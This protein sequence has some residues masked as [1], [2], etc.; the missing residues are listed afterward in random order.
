MRDFFTR[1]SRQR[2]QERGYETETRSSSELSHFAAREW[3]HAWKSPCQVV[4]PPPHH[5]WYGILHGTF[6]QF[7][8]FHQISTAVPLIWYP[9]SGPF[10]FL[11]PL[12]L[13]WLLFPPPI[14]SHLVACR[15]FLCMHF[16]PIPIYTRD[17]HTR[18]E[19][20]KTGNGLLAMKILFLLSHHASRVL[21]MTLTIIDHYTDFSF[22]VLAACS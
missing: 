5:E 9:A 18:K 6:F 22:S 14:S 17:T 21:G 15:N 20:G 16:M 10:A 7:T 2:S 13:T 1:C 4:L 19:R 3:L 8:S 12:D 11:L